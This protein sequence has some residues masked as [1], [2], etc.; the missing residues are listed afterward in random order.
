MQVLE[1]ERLI[2]RHLTLDDV[3]DL[4]QILG[5]PKA[6]R[7]YPAPFTRAQTEGWIRHALTSY[8]QHEVGLWAVIRKEGQRFLGD[9]GLTVQ[10]VE[11]GTDLEIG[12][13]IIR[14]YQGQG[15]ATEAAYAC[16]DYAFAVLK[17]P[18]VISIVDLQN[19]PSRRVAEKVHAQMR[20]FI[21]EQ[22]GQV[23]CLYYT[24]RQQWPGT[25]MFRTPGAGDHAKAGAFDSTP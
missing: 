4:W 11:G 25:R 13:H 10:P 22:H 23:M 20:E 14:R 18:R 24:D 21:W 6:M 8:A 17:A 5:D 7:Y 2:L 16:R 19:R 9:C 15:F 3:D 1:T 12:Y